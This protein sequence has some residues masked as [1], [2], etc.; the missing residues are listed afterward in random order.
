MISVVCL[1]SGL[2]AIALGE[3]IIGSGA[4]SLASRAVLVVLLWVFGLSFLSVV[5]DRLT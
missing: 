5:L 4:D 2:M 1:V 3:D